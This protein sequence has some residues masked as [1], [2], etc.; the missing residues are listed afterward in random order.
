MPER[1]TEIGLFLLPFAL[2]VAL[3]L[4]ARRGVPFAAVL[5]STVLGLMLLLG[6][7]W[8]FGVDRAIPPGQPYVPAVVQGGRVTGGTAPR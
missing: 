6:A 5:A 4:A 1:L 7:L 8:W 2:F 3:R